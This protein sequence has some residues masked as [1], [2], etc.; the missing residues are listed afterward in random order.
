MVDTPIN[1]MT[2]FFIIT[3][4]TNLFILRHSHLYITTTKEGGYKVHNKKAVKI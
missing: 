1:G 3:H 2:Y 4:A